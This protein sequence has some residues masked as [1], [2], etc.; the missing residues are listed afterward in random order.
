MLV[1]RSRATPAAAHVERE[2]GR[3]RLGCPRPPVHG[4]LAVARVYRNHEVFPEPL[5]RIGEERRRQRGRS[6]HDAIGAGIECRRYLVGRAVAA[7]DL[8]REAPGSRDPFDEVECRRPT[9]SAVEVD[10][11]QATSA[12]VAE[13][14][15]KLDR[16][17]TLDRHRLPSPLGEADHASFEDVDC[18]DDSELLC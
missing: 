16:V 7:T 1:T 12:L 18:R 4:H 8:E 13:S 6:D 11:V 2:S 3:R 10:E 9:E 5:G 15:G 17:T 14:A